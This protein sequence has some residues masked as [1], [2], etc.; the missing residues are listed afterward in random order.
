M[1]GLLLAHSLQISSA[2]NKIMDPNVENS[3]TFFPASTQQ[4]CVKFFQDDQQPPYSQRNYGA[5][6]PTEMQQDKLN[7]ESSEAAKTS[8]SQRTW[9]PKAVKPPIRSSKTPLLDK[10]AQAKVQTSEY[11]HKRE[12]ATP[13]QAKVHA[14]ESSRK[15]EV[16]APVQAKVQT[17][18]SSRKREVAAPV[19]AK[20]QTSESSRKRE[21]AA[22]VQAK[23]QTSESS[24]KREVAAPVQAKVQTSDSSRK[25]EVAAPVQAKVQTSESLHKREVAARLQFVEPLRATA[26]TFECPVQSISRS[27]PLEAVNDLHNFSR[28]HEEPKCKEL[29]IQQTTIEVENDPST[30]EVKPPP[31]QTHRN[32]ASREIILNKLCR[33]VENLGDENEVYADSCCEKCSDCLCRSCTCSISISSCCTKNSDEAHAGI[34]QLLETDA[35]RKGRAQGSKDFADAVFPLVPDVLRL[36]WV[37]IEFGLALTGLTL[38]VLTTSLN[39]N[40]A[41]NI[42]H[43]VLNSLACVLAGIDSF[44][45]LKNSTTLKKCCCCCRRLGKRDGKGKLGCKQRCCSRLTDL[46][47]ILR[48]I[49]SEAILY[50]LLICD[51]FDL[52][53][54]QGFKGKSTGE[55]LSF[56][57]FVVSLVSMFLTVYLARIIVLLGMIK[58]ATAVRSPN[59]KMITTDIDNEGEKIYD[60]DIKQSAVRY[61]TF[62]CL[63]VVF[64]ML[65][66]LLMYISIAA[67]IRH[68]NRHFYEDE[69][70]DEGIRVT[71]YLWYM[72][73]AGYVL[74]IMG[75]LTFF[76]VTYYWSQQ[77]PVGYRLDMISIFKMTEYGMVDLSNMRKEIAEKKEKMIDAMF[78][79]GDP[80]GKQAKILANM[81]RLLFKPLKED[82]EVIFRKSLL[83]KFSYPFKTPSSIVICIVYI[84]LQFAFMVCAALAVDEMGAVVIHILNGSG[85]V[86]YYISVVALGIIANIYTVL[87]VAIWIPLIIVAIIVILAI[88]CICIIV[89]V[90]LAAFGI[91]LKSK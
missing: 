72:M 67:K 9:Q 74:P 62:F 6:Y 5:P 88:V 28:S 91:Q 37:I 52:I 50:P 84:A 3:S 85:W 73:A 76:I 18:E 86:Y 56:A 69:N 36:L 11:L 90:V 58:N 54:G 47:D 23:V 59:K 1:L 20:V 2:P 32:D 49:L 31:Q 82:F 16:A 44:Y 63:H 60:P 61:Q 45:S 21:V 53:I 12:F 55:R 26:M 64:Q 4:G 65:V 29:M 30:V 39:Q 13:V 83:V 10:S 81:D 48:L 38:S 80:A 24:R 33:E 46:M 15:R 51:I 79:G 40:R 14:S 77:Y 75:L 43:L 19:Q 68:D 8:S 71:N 25:R 70:S 41:F 57:L 66:Q 27:H 22:P 7:N 89:I 17:S 34:T 87:V 35:L 78:S 42:L